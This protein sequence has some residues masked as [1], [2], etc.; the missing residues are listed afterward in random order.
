MHV[1]RHD[2]VT[3]DRKEIAQADAL[4]RIFKQFHGPDRREVSALREYFNSEAVGCDKGGLPPRSP[5]ARDRGHPH[6]TLIVGARSQPFWRMCSTAATRPG[7]SCGSA[8]AAG[9]HPK[10]RSV[11]LVI[12]PIEMAGTAKSGK[13]IP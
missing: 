6:H 7:T 10:S 3:S 13:A 1:L 4:Q 11:W 2:D 8:S 5:K 9:S 12:G